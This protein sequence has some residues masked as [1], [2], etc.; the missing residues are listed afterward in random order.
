MDKIIRNLDLKYFTNADAIYRLIGLI[1]W[2]FKRIWHTEKAFSHKHSSCLQ[3]DF[4][5]ISKG[6]TRSTTSETSIWNT[7][8]I[9]ILSLLLIAII[10][11]WL[12][13]SCQFSVYRES[14]NVHMYNY[15]SCVISK[16]TRKSTRKK[17]IP[18]YNIWW[19][20]GRRV[21]YVPCV[22]VRVRLLHE[23]TERMLMPYARR[24]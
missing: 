6:W 10:V 5:I 24:W 12:V 15:E 9:K 23:C 21:A 18:A 1:I 13:G 2:N 16:N 8:P 11:G 19:Y 4:F 22:R 17:N 14:Q 7:S 20:Y 3:G